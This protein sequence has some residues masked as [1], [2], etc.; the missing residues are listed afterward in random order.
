MILLLGRRGIIKAENRAVRRGTQGPFPI[1][2]IA[3]ATNWGDSHSVKQR[4]QSE[5]E[6]ETGAGVQADLFAQ[7][8]QESGRGNPNGI[9]AGQQVGSVVEARTVSKDS[10][11]LRRRARNLDHGT[12]LGNAG[13]IA[14]V[15]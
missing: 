13:G 9:E 5:I 10:N 4:A 8:G 6:M 15:T 7:G 11:A 12:H 1:V 3:G 2:V 14:H